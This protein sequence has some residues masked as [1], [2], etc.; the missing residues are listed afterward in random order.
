MAHPLGDEKTDQKDGDGTDDGEDD[1]DTGFPLGP[2]LACDQVVDG[3]LA[4]SDKRHI[5]SGHCDRYLEKQTVS[6][7]EHSQLKFESPGSRIDFQLCAK[8]RMPNAK[9]PRQVEWRD[10]DE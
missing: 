5:K 9:R 4:A 6:D 1:D 10:H 3:S 7:K 8:L 2:V